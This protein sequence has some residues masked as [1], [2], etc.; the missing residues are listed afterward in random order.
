M[1]EYTR[2]F[3]YPKQR[4]AIFND[5]RW[6]IVE[7]STK[8]GKAQPLDALVYTP[9]GPV[10]MGNLKIGDEVLD[11]SGGISLVTGVFPQG[12]RQSYVVIFNDGTQVEC[13]G[14]H[15]WETK[16]YEKPSE[17]L[18]TRELADIP[19]YKLRR[20][21]VPKIKPVQ[22][23][24]KTVPLDPYL[25]GVLIGDGGLTTECV[26][27][28]SMDEEIV[29][30]IE[31]CIPTDHFLRKEN[32]DNYDYII[33]GENAPRLRQEGRHIR[34][35]LQ[36][37]GMVGKYSYEKGIPLEYIYNDI[38][39]RWRVLQGIMDTD[40]SVNEKGQPILEQTSEQLVYAITELVQS[41]GGSTKYSSDTSAGYIEK[42]SGQDTWVQG[43]RRYRLTIRLGEDNNKCFTLK[44]KL[45]KLK[46]QKKSGNR[47]FN[48]IHLGRQVEMQCISVSNP[49]HLYLTNGFIPTHNTVGCMA[50]IIEQALQGHPNWN[51]WWIAPVSSQADIA[52]RRIKEGMT[53]GSFTSRETPEKQIRTINGAFIWFKSAD[54]PDSLYGEDVYSAVID[55]ASRCN[56]KS[57]YAVRSTLTAT[58]GPCRII[59]NVQGRKNWFYH[60][61]R[62]AEKG[63]FNYS[64]AK[65]TAQDAVDAGVLDAAEIEDARTSLPEHVFRELY[66]AEPGDDTGNPFGS[67]HIAACISDSLSK[68]PAVAYGIDLAKKQD[69]LVV[70]GL[71]ENGNVCEF[72]RWRNVPWRESIRRIWRIVGED[73]PALVDSTGVGDP[74]L[75]ELQHEHGNFN[76]YH[77]TQSSKQ[78]LME[79]LA[80]S[81]QGHEI[82]YPD[83]VIRNELDT[84]EYHYTRTGVTYTAPEGYNDDCVCLAE[85]TIINANIGMVP[86]ENIKVGDTV[87]THKGHYCK[88]IGVGARAANNLYNVEITGRPDLFITGEH[89]ILSAYS[90]RHNTHDEKQNQLEYGVESWKSIDGGLS[91]DY[92]AASVCIGYTIDIDNLDLLVIA[93]DNFIADGPVLTSTMI[94]YGKRVINRNTNPVKRFIDIDN[95]FCF[96][97]GYYLAE[98][99]TNKRHQVNFASHIREEAIRTKVSSIFSK[100]N[101]TMGT[102]QNSE[103]GC[104]SWVSSTPMAEFFR[105]NFGKGRDKALPRWAEFLPIEKQWNILIGYLLGDGNFTEGPCRVSTISATAAFQLYGISQRLKLPVSLKLRY[106]D[107]G[108]LWNLAWGI[109]TTNK[110][111]AEIPNELLSAKVIGKTD[112]TKDQTQIRFSGNGYMLGR[113]NKIEKIEGEYLVYNLRVEHDESYVA[114]GTV[115]HNCSLALA[116]QMWSETTVGANMMEYYASA[117]RKNIER[118]SNIEDKN[119]PD[120]SELWSRIQIITPEDIFDNEL[121]Q[122]YNETLSTLD[123]SKSNTCPKCG[124]PVTGNER[125]TDGVVSWHINCSNLR[126]VA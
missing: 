40:G 6:S 64:Y 89:P 61:S 112:F 102:T 70:I 50:W 23:T 49:R 14:S 94:R 58:R 68:H 90:Y 86:I 121:T 66:F 1:V 15:L 116:R 47:L 33:V 32:G 76:G 98:G 97:L 21:N 84:F 3:L 123:K 36:K 46:P 105:F 60:L 39:V 103:N 8:S 59:G 69:Y 95:D 78:K 114:N 120:N 44:R 24:S 81:I 13:D 83:G 79:G 12:I 45:D 19:H 22:F 107:N 80:V 25:I 67:Q 51:H 52:F 100:L 48:S 37:L 125:I 11:H 74:V 29:N 71:D 35:L 20:T 5:C 117:A 28:S 63:E 43:R 18:T 16:F 34:G 82:T 31:N 54:N 119:T 53:R 124:Q 110:I 42:K 75:E 62:K 41:L 99:S 104:I 101:L 38:E 77:F 72:H 9:C 87:L 111:L 10:L 26:R 17:I 7:A 30:T 73:V 4:E 109:P 56:E 93:P 126:R 118:V 88:V 108:E 2:P 27:F 92:A 106:N 115:V 113:I 91:S 57:W 85:G 65:I 55:E 96:L 122:L